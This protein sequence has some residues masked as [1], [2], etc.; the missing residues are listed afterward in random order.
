MKPG[1]V[2]ITK[3]EANRQKILH[4]ARAC[5]ELGYEAATMRKIAEVAGLSTGSLFSNWSGKEALYLEV[6]GHPPI[7][8]EQGRALLLAAETALGENRCGPLY[9]AIEVIRA[10]PRSEAA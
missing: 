9:R 3:Q 5:F 6:Y 4:A 7:S 8:V 2:R 10:Q 1:S